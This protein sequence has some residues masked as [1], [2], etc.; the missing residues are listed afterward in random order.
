MTEVKVNDLGLRNYINLKPVIVPRSSGKHNGM[1]RDKMHIIERLMTKIMVPGHRGKKH[2]ITSGGF[3]TNTQ[4]IY[5]E[6]KKALEIIEKKTKKNP[7]QVFIEAIENAAILEEVA[8]YRLGGIIARQSVVTSPQRRLDLALRYLGQGIYKTSF[9]SR[10][11]LAEVIASEIIS[12]Y[13]RD[14]KS[15]VIQEKNRI[16]REAEGAR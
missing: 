1:H 7:V 6:V 3:P 11:T 14:S 8:S 2:K 15:F 10:K 5:L 9:R 16:E 4:T 12:A 13:E